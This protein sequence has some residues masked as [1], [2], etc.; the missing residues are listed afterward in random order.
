MRF[1]KIFYLYALFVSTV[2]ASIGLVGPRHP[3]D[4]PL[5]FPKGSSYEK[6]WKRVDS[7]TTK[8]LYRKA[9]ERVEMIYSQAKK[10]KNDPQ[11]I[12]SIMHRM[13]F[14]RYVEEFDQERAL[15]DLQKELNG[16]KFPLKNMLHSIIAETY[17]NYYQSNRWKFIER[18]VT[19]NF[20]PE[21]VATWDLSHLVDQVFKHHRASLENTDS[22]KRTPVGYFEPVL[23]NYDSGGRKMR[24]TLYD[25]LA[26]RALDFYIN[27]EA[28]ITKP[29]QT[30]ELSSEDYFRPSDEFPRFR[31]ENTDSLSRKYDAMIL[32]QQLLNFHAADS[33]PEQ[34][35]DVDLK[36]LQF[37]RD[38][39]TSE[40]RDSLYLEALYE[41]EKRVYNDPSSSEVAYQIAIWFGNRSAKYKPLEGDQYRWDR[42]K[43]LDI[44]RSA[45][46]RHPNSHGA[47]LCTALE[48]TI[49]RKEMDLRTEKVNTPLAPFRALFTH[50]NMNKIYLR[51]VQIDPQKFDRLRDKYYSEELMDQLV[52]LP[53]LNA[54][55]Q[56]V[57]NDSDFQ[58]HTA[59]I[60]IPALK[61]GYYLLLASSSKN[62]S[63]KGEAISYGTCWV[64]NIAY[65]SRT[66]EDYS[67]EFTVQQRMSGEVMKGA[68][69][70]L[71]YERY[72]NVTR[73]YEW[74]K[75][76]KYTTDSNG[77]FLV[78]PKTEN[79][80]SFYMEF[81][82]GTD[83]I[84]TEHTYYQYKHYPEKK[85]F[86]TRSFIFTD[87]GIYRP[88][89]IIYFKGIM[90]ESDGDTN[91]ILPNRTVSV[92]LYDVNYQI[93]ATLQLTT[94][95]Y[96][97]YSGSFTAPM[98]VLNGTMQIKD[99]YSAK[100]VSVEEYKRPKFEVSINKLKGEY[101]LNDKVTIE[102]LAKAYSGARIDGANVKYR[103]V[104]S[105][106]FPSWCYWRGYAPSSPEM[107]ITSGFTTSNDTGG[108]VIP[109]E[110]IPDPSVLRKY[111]PTYSY[112]V[113]ADITDINGETQSTSTWVDASYSSLMLSLH[114][115]DLLVTGKSVSHLNVLTTNRS[116]DPVAASGIV[117]VSRIVTPGR[118]YR[119][120]Y[121]PVP[122]QQLITSGEFER[123]FPLDAY[124][125]ENELRS[126]QV[127]YI[128]QAGFQSFMGKKDGKDTGFV[129]AKVQN[130]L[131]YVLQSPGTYLFELSSTD[132]FGEV[133]K[134]ERV[135]TVVNPGV[136]QIPTNAV[137]WAHLTEETVEPGEKAVILLGTAEAT[138]L[139]R[140]EVEQDGKIIRNEWMK[141][142]K[143]QRRLEIPILEKYRGN[144]AVHFYTMYN[145]RI[146]SRSFNIN[147]PWTNKELSIEYETFRN[148]LLPGEKEEWKIRIKGPK[149]EKAMAEM[150]TAMYDA[151][152]DAFRPN[153]WYFSVYA[154]M[155]GTKMWNVS[156]SYG[157]ND[158]NQYSQEWNYHPYYPVRYY[159]KLNW[160]GYSVYG[161][162]D[163]YY[164]DSYEGDNDLRQM[165]EV[166]INTKDS[167]PR[168]NG[169]YKAD[170]STGGA[171]APSEKKEMEEERSKVT[172]GSVT[173]TFAND[174]PE[175]S[176]GENTEV[177]ARSNFAETAFF[178][179]D[180]QTDEN[181]S[182]VVKFTVPESL[183]KWKVMSF[184]HTKDLKFG[185]ITKE[186]VTQKELMVVPN[187][188][189]F[190]REND[191][192]TFTA[193]ITNLSAGDMSGTADLILYDALSMKEITPKVMMAIHGNFST[194]GE[195]PFTAGKG[196]STSVS[197]DLEIPEGYGAI[198]YKVVAKAGKFTDGEEM[199]VPV[200]T[201]RM[202]VTESMPL[203]VR[204]KQSKTFTFE[205]FMNRNGG[206]T[207]L[208]DH[209]FTLEF[210]S[211]PAWYAVQS[212]PYLME[213]P[214]E[215]AEQTFSRFYSNSI[216]SHIANSH[217]KVKAVFDAWKSKSPDAFLSNLQ[218]NQELKSAILEETPW[219]LDAKD[220]SERKKRVGLLFDLNRMSA[221]L[222]KAF[223]KLKKM[224]MSN[225]GWPWFEGFPD[226]RYITQHIITG[227]GHLDHLGVKSM[228]SDYKTWNMIKDGVRYLDN[229]IAEDYRWILKHDK[230]HMHEDH[231][232]YFA[233]QYLYARSYFMDVEVSS[234]NKAA[235][236]YYKGQAAKYWLNKGRYMQGMIALGLYRFDE[237]SMVP[238]DIM[239]SLKDN[240]IVSEEMGMYWK[241][242]YSG[243]YWYEAPIECQALLIEAFDEV[244]KD[245]KAVDDLKVW[246]LKSKQTQN[247]Q[248]T[249]ATTEA[250]Y[251]LLLRGT[252]WLST[253]SGV[254]IMLG[255]MKVDK[256]SIPDLKVEEGSNYFKHSWTG[257]DIKR[258]MGTIKITK[259]DEGVSWGAV[260]WQ[261]FEQLDK[262][263]PHETPLKLNK[264]LFVERNTAS[265]PV[266]TPVTEKTILKIGDKI[267][268]RIELRVDRDMEYV[269]MK[270]MRASGFEPTNVFS[271]TRWQDGLY[272]YESTRDAATNF[273]FHR[274]SKG[275]YVFEY[276]L[277]VS[278]SGDFSNGITTIQCMYAPEFT[279]HSEG[280]R[281]QVGK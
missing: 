202:L 221:E 167:A 274:L 156:G 92:S 51:V 273:F 86:Y 242:N 57:P 120:R 220:E 28:D 151:S 9:L 263:T 105:A 65:V 174:T 26:H 40:F 123:D 160:F 95:E 115:P 153:Y 98:G 134:E 251:A 129:T 8:G 234:G 14:E 131:N 253:E 76:E 136:N 17:W 148:K 47:G 213:Y 205:K 49:L 252:D 75:G 118:T 217:P 166:S 142:P 184:A 264:K 271:G 161:Y 146:Y 268:V 180:L 214:Y 256:Q 181:G 83:M 194:I 171:P 66:R 244:A 198:T 29:A 277:V 20:K 239:K 209:R 195:R 236:D 188:P 113:Y 228:R 128:T 107:E 212:L 80:R 250:V 63:Y 11:V 208:R 101:R 155:S 225:G 82:N 240:A 182:L 41:L 31:L 88:G 192:I 23:Y 245:Q 124:G 170:K 7:L 79:G 183:T 179:P 175:T 103:V 144:I 111:S 112:K 56:T 235:F 44:A 200:L 187:A 279:S 114:I 140:A 137:F 74:I 13:K 93:A 1:P 62:F 110:L 59:E 169:F 197:W 162:Y 43:A 130:F 45:A 72:N 39:H 3:G 226:D 178:Y 85:H 4:E 50:R 145:N 38:H 102:G 231:L 165:D 241:E 168:K 201:N 25:F 61:E 238:K 204:S 52:K 99:G 247:W 42:R 16:S 173:A 260:Y 149:G 249:K 125:S 152:L 69:G 37:V 138:I 24:P 258:D 21:D 186:L 139:L 18:S 32:F 191:R 147:V 27:K 117:K 12:K 248:T 224:Q 262:I 150:V 133:V 233:I 267:K 203:P 68:S 90:L 199:A 104:R 257:G 119:D 232:N 206:S 6:E 218:K 34:R 189:R 164:Y 22:L 159:D 193:K 60:R 122:D 84:Q 265:G 281:V 216:A 94:N 158:W 71:M 55:E 89:Q 243:F 2:F 36:R 163:Y 109:F 54:W 280:I 70:Q 10:D 30:F 5:K 246:L 126:R 261:Y 229:R 108:F 97:S 278:H 96:G 230:A 77:Y 143:G 190:F 276:P 196:K 64:S 127:Q 222:N 177:K 255:N 227:F 35:V 157:S 73:N 121:W 135:I 172:L 106:R 46:K 132:K 53:V 215:C 237:K 154:S 211:N 78:P 33:T 207:T 210:T 270:D 81:R 272:Y 259:K 254:E 266:I 275:T 269:H 176:G 87:R 15:N 19:V 48:Q 223:T 141:L 91:R 100:S 67:V 58:I 116:G 185:Q 219:V